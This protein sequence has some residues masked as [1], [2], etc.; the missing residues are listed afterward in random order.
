MAPINTQPACFA[1]FDICI[2][3]SHNKCQ[4]VKRENT[5]GQLAQDDVDGDTELTHLHLNL[6]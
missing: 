6:W 2:C 4:S 5:A 3:Q 1:P